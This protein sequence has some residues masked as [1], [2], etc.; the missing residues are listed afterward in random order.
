MLGVFQPLCFVVDLETK[1][2]LMP[3]AGEL[4]MLN[5]L[6]IVP[7]LEHAMLIIGVNF[8]LFVLRPWVNM[9]LQGSRI[10]NVP[11]IL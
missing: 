6:L 4:M 5:R 2:G 3:A 9:V 1:N 11:G 7:G 8:Y 10:M